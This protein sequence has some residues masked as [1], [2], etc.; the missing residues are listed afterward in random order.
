MRVLDGDEAIVDVG[1]DRRAG[2]LCNRARLPFP[3][4]DRQ[5]TNTA[6]RDPLDGFALE[7]PDEEDVSRARSDCDQDG[8]IEERDERRRDAQNGSPCTE[9]MIS[10]TN[11][12]RRSST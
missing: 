9:R 12:V 10:R 2:E 5:G 8:D 7:R 3:R 4:D 11:V 6:A 1:V